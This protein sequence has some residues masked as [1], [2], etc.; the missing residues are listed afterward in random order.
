MESHGND[1][2][3]AEKPKKGLVFKSLLY[4]KKIDRA[5]L[6]AEFLDN[7]S[8]V[9]QEHRLAFWKSMLGKRS[10]LLELQSSKP[11]FTAHGSSKGIWSI[12]P[13]QYQAIDSILKSHYQYLKNVIAEV[14][15]ISYKNM[16]ELNYCIYLLDRDLLPLNEPEIVR[17]T[18]T[19]SSC[20]ADEVI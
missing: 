4:A 11:L 10:I 17:P 5:K 12:F 3:N 1:K 2:S 19:C 13:S 16:E 9:P 8:S 15:K 14:L 7:Y 20:Q 18:R 6:K